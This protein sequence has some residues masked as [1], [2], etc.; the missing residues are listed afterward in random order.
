MNKLEEYFYE[1]EKTLG[2]DKWSHYFD[3]YDNHFK[4]FTE[5]VP[6]ILEVGVAR[7]GSLEM[8]NYYFNGNC[9]LYGVDIDQRCLRIPRMLN[10]SNIQ[11]NIGDQSDRNFWRKYLNDKPKFDIVIEDGG[12]TMIQQIV[13]FE[14]VFGHVAENGVYLCE[15]LHTSYQSKYGGG[16]K[17]N[18]TFIEYSKNFIDGINSHHSGGIPEKFRKIRENTKSIHHYESVVVLEKGINP[19]S[20]SIRK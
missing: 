3:I 20:E 18:D 15:D 6:N 7:G 2:I 12:H 4:R 5:T 1:K 10:A 19:R 8:W 13:T 16:Y 11:I 14:E 17:K 9:N